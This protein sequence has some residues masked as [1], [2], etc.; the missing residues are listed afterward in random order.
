MDADHRLLLRNAR[1]L[2]NSRNAAVSVD[3][4]YGHDCS[5]SCVVVSYFLSVC[6]G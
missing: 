3:Y 1:P 6:E 5:L 4:G 2:L